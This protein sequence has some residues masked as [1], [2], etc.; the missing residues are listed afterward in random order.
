MEPEQNGNILNKSLTFGNL[1]I[2]VAVYR[3][4]FLF[5]NFERHQISKPILLRICPAMN[6]CLTCADVYT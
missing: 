2:I 6:A 3:I 4:L 5:S 1:D